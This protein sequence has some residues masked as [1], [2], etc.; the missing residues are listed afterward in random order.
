MSWSIE[1]PKIDANVTRATVVEWL[2]REGDRVEPGTP[3]VEVETEKAVFTIDAEQAGVV[4]RILIQQGRKLPVGT[5]LG[6]IG[7]DG[8]D[9][10]DL[11]DALEQDTLVSA[12][13]VGGLDDEYAVDD[14]RD[15]LLWEA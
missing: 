5:C 1:I 12:G 3:L 13:P 9:V 8:E 6:V 10:S 4:R 2:V 11:P 7:A 14:Y 15:A